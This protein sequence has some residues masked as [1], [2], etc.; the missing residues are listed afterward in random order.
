MLIGEVP[1]Y[2]STIRNFI[3]A[4]GNLF[5]KL[6]VCREEDSSCQFIKVPVAYGPKNKWLSRLQEDPDLTNNVGIVL[7]RIGFEITGYQYDGSRKIGAMGASLNGNLNGERVKLFNPIPY[8]VGI[9][10]STMCKTQ[11]DSLQL[12]EQIVPYFS[13]HMTVKINILPE[14]NV[15]K[16]VPIVLQSVNV[17]DSY[18]GGLNETRTVIQNFNFVAQLD[19]FG[20]IV[21]PQGVIKETIADLNSTTV[22]GSSNAASNQTYNAEVNPRYASKIDPHT[23]DESWTLPTTF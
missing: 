3:I 12:L 10:L 8:D 17:E 2:N 16:A 23:V 13:P 1:F 6:T 15:I 20:P 9:T 7:P 11:E 18:Q 14:F 5:S 4:F 22:A 21:Q 19:L